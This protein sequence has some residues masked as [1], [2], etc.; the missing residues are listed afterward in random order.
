[1]YILWIESAKVFIVV[2][3]PN[4]ELV[5]YKARIFLLKHLLEYTLYLVAIL[6]VTLVFSNLI[7]KKQRQAFDATLE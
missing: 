4:M 1:M 6:I 2:L 5:A 3:I 7:N